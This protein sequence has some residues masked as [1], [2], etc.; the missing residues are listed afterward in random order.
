MARAAAGPA[1]LA[2]ARTAWYDAVVGRGLPTQMVLG[3]FIA[4]VLV[5]DCVDIIH[6]EGDQPA[7][8]GEGEGA[9]TGE[10]ASDAGCVCE[11]GATR[12][13]GTREASI[14]AS[15]C[16]EWVLQPCPPR[17]PICWEGQCSMCICETGSFQCVSASVLQV[18]DDRCIWTDVRCAAGETCQDG[19]C[20]P[21]GGEVEPEC[22]LTECPC[23]DAVCQPPGRCF[24]P[25]C[26]VDA[27]CPAGEVCVDRACEPVVEDCVP[28][29]VNPEAAVS[30]QWVRVCPGDFLMGSPEDEPGRWDNEV[31]HSVEITRPYQ[32]RATE[33]PQAE[34]EA[35][36]RDNPSY[37]EG[38]GG[39]CPVDSVS[40]YDAVEFCNA[41]SRSEGQEECY[42]IS[43]Q[44][45][46]WP[47]GLDCR[48][49]RLPT[50]AE[51]EYAARAGT[52]T[53]FHT[54]E[55]TEIG[56]GHDP[57]LDRAGWY[58][59]NSAGHPHPVAQKEPNA[60]GLCD[61][62]G[63]VWEWVWDGYRDD[64]EALPASDPRQDSGDSR[65]IRGGSWLNVAENCRAAYRYWYTPSARRRYLGFRPARSAFS[66][67]LNP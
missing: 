25:E 42:V 2:A 61:V 17:Y 60:W 21:A 44:T 67:P 13:E 46:S 22:D 3:L 49:Y 40:W 11:P 59:G 7:V 55:L 32:I 63:N 58:C 34:W 62:H 30:E 16:Q 27:D 36:M 37:H 9:G 57:A 6:R 50:E 51:W 45:V 38:C 14:C 43:G 12:C 52:A 20:R 28:G 5:S 65:V 66:G 19:Q 26:S 1:P 4:A 53:A 35:V 47:R 48:G 33:V 56:C 24:C 15:S 23:P 18:C 10:A 31:Q 64:Y 41:L 8:E 39:S 54:R 29:P